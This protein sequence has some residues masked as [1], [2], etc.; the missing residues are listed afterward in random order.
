MRVTGL[1]SLPLAWQALPPANRSS[2]LS[3]ISPSIVSNL[4]VS[5]RQI[6]SEGTRTEPVAPLT[7]FFR[8]LLATAGRK[9]QS[10]AEF[11]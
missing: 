8:L 4:N 7:L 11:R 9:I 5:S 6:R 10:S 1:G 2:R 3:Q